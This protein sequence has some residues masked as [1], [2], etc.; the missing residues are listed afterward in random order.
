LHGRGSLCLCFCLYL[1]A[2]PFVVALT[3]GR[4]S[5]QRWKV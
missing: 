3:E 5:V 2:G 4:G 1:L